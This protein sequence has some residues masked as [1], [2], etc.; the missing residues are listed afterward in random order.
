MQ[1]AGRVTQRCNYDW[2]LKEGNQVGALLRGRGR[3]LRPEGDPLGPLHS[4]HGTC[5]CQQV[6]LQLQSCTLQSHDVQFCGETGHPLLTAGRI[7]HNGEAAS[8]I[9]P[10]KSASRRSFKNIF[11][12]FPRVCKEEGVAVARLAQ[13]QHTPLFKRNTPID[14]TATRLHLRRQYASCPVTFRWFRRRSEIR[15]EKKAKW[16]SLHY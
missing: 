5:S 3:G 6:W 12:A 16:P 10:Q 8:G 7:L 1:C 14:G 15:F 4:D 13:N 9:F 2:A 11:T